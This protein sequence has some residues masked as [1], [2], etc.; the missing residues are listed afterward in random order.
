MSRAGL[1]FLV[2]APLLLTCSDGDPVWR[3]N[4]VLA[5][6]R[7]RK[8]KI[9]DSDAIAAGSK[10][11]GFSMQHAEIKAGTAWHQFLARTRFE[12]RTILT[13]V[14]FWV[15]LALAV[16][17]SLGNFFSLSQ[18]YGTTVYPVTRSLIGPYRDAA[19]L[20]VSIAS[21]IVIAPEETASPSAASAASGSSVSIS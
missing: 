10:P 17:L 8:K 20:A 5:K 4:F 19:T 1:A 15:L 7:R 21:V 6:S 14:F 2:L 9:E 16:A 12:V 3:F 11:V 18:I 13:S